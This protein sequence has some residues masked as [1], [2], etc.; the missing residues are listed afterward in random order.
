MRNLH[1][2]I[3]TLCIA[4]IGC[5]LISFISCSNHTYRGL[6][7]WEQYSSLSYHGPYILEFKSDRG[8]LVYYG[9]IHSMNPGDP[10]F[11]DI[12]K[13]WEEFQ[14]TLAFSEGGI[15][16]LAKS[17]E[18][19]I[20]KYGEQGILRFLSN[21]DGI[22]IQSIEPDMRREALHLSKYFP[23][24][25]VKVFYIL[26]Q[27]YIHRRMMKDINDCRYADT[28]LNELSKIKHFKHTPG[29]LA[30]FEEM[31]SRLFPELQDWK[32]VPRSWFSS[33]KS[34][35]WTNEMC[36]VVND[37]RNQHMLEILIR[38]LKKGK[39]IFCVVG[40]SHVVMQEPVLFSVVT[41]QLGGKINRVECSS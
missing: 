36:R 22:S 9:A 33:K 35:R 11:S 1:Y 4:S 40:R 29:S 19:A 16:P 31:V 26:R 38:E 10:Q 21:R 24:D 32:Y 39:K 2:K 27:A 37:F 12:E 25:L 6:I 15:W 23:S 20:R 28:I 30:D 5:S 13:K 18:D 34:E 7:T 41:N 17:R 3:K 14:P 8:S